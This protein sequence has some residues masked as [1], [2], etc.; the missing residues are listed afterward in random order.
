M[1]YY[2]HVCASHPITGVPENH[3]FSYQQPR[4][5]NAYI[6][7]R[8]YNVGT[9]NQRGYATVELTDTLVACQEYYVEFYVNLLNES[10]MSVDR[11]CAFLSSSP[12]NIPG[13]CAITRM[14]VSSNSNME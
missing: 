6:S 13:N 1:G 5:G 7:V 10:R 2:Y 9:I 3:I 12:R 14:T 8:A 11:F 4:T